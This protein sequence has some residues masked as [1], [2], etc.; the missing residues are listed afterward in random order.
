MPDIS[1]G[2]VGALL[3][4]IAQTNGTAGRH[5]TAWSNGGA[6]TILLCLTLSM[7]ASCATVQVITKEQLQGQRFSSDTTPI[8]HLYADNWGIYLFKFIP[9]IT[10]N[11]EKPGRPLL[12]SDTVRVDLL[13]SSVAQ[14][15]RRLGGDTLMDLRTRDRSQW[16]PWSLVFWLNEFEVS[17]NVSRSTPDAA[18]FR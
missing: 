4:E 18:A 10:G 13:V 2:G 7:L 5:L 11:L 6:R 8:A 3:D 12:F 9:L 1:D 15:S 16:I 17:A 14:E